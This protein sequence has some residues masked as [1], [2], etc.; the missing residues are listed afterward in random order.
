M[1]ENNISMKPMKV[2]I[3]N[4][5][6]ASK[7]AYSDPVDAI[8]DELT[9]NFFDHTVA[10]RQMLDKQIKNESD[11]PPAKMTFFFSNGPSK[12][13]IR[14]EQTGV[15]GILER[16]AYVTFSEKTKVNDSERGSRG[17]GWKTTVLPFATKVLTESQISD[18]INDYYQ[19]SVEV[20]H[21]KRD[22][23]VSEW[24][25]F[26][27]TIFDRTLTSRGTTISIF[28]ISEDIKKELESKIDLIL[29][30]RWWGVLQKNSNYQIVIKKENQNED[31]IISKNTLPQIPKMSDELK[32]IV[33]KSKTFETGQRPRRENTINNLSVYYSKKSLA[34]GIREGIA[35]I[36]NGH[37]IDWYKSDYAYDIPGRIFGWVEADFL[38]DHES[39]THQ[40][41][42]DT[43]A[44]K[45]TKKELDTLIMPLIDS[46]KDQEMGSIEVESGD[47][48]ISDLNDVIDEF[49]SSDRDRVKARKNKKEK[50]EDYDIKFTGFSIN[51][52]NPQSGQRPKFKISIEYLK[53]IPNNELTISISLLSKK[54]KNKM[55]DIKSDNFTI[56]TPI[57]KKQSFDFSYTIPEV[58]PFYSCETVCECIISTNGKVSNNNRK[59]TITI[60]P[61]ISS[62][63]TSST[64]YRRGEIVI[65]S[66]TLFQCK[67]NMEETFSVNFKFNKGKETLYESFSPTKVTLKND[68]EVSLSLI[69]QKSWVIPQIIERRSY[70]LIC[71]IYDENKI[72]LLEKKSVDFEVENFILNLSAPS[73]HSRNDEVPVKLA[74]HVTNPLASKFVGIVKIRIDKEVGSCGM[75]EYDLELDPNESW[76]NESMEMIIGTNNERGIYSVVC[77]VYSTTGELFDSDYTKIKVDVLDRPGLFSDISYSRLLQDKRPAYIGGDG[78]VHINV[79]HP[80]FERLGSLDKLTKKDFLSKLLVILYY[81]LSDA[82]KL[83]ESTQWWDFEEKV[84]KL[85]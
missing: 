69:R 41:L 34:R 10:F 62:V 81:A 85:V 30:Q 38:R 46:I 11:G 45:Y 29:I 40:G 78:L 79:L 83:D 36:C 4:T 7:D 3:Y 56:E 8:V 18:N 82:N 70:T 15:T 65:P 58:D 61:I 28:G 54:N 1:A 2:N 74:C 52:K 72:N 13:Q 75:I 43:S 33:I 55:F 31:T 68:E 6:E 66:V 42:K 48:M 9:Q 37:T 23:L 16:K 53:E 14:I 22:I 39:S 59:L 71:E 35:I 24:F 77:E 32:P 63:K 49:L 21:E 84:M 17:Q 27:K 67:E 76:K 73:S 19:V 51:N 57:G 5:V 50:H 44:V 25:D 20:D 80:L 60:N 47:D 64:D 26:P 12:P